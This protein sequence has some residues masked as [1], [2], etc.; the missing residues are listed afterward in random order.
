VAIGNKNVSWAIAPTGNMGKQLG[1][2]PYRY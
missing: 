1:E 2:S